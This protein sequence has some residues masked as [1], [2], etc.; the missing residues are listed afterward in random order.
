MS[1]NEEYTGLVNE[2]VFRVIS[3]AEY[4]EL[5][6][7]TGAP[8]IPTMVVLIFNTNGL[9]NDPHRAKCRIFVLSNLELTPWT[10]N[11][12]YTSMVLQSVVRLLTSDAIG[13]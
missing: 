3:K 6:R 13:K 7:Q 11:D 10:K 8:T 1:Y 12:C 2:N 9:T 4:P 5:L